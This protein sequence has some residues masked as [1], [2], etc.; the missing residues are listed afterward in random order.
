MVRKSNYLFWDKEEEA[1][2]DDRSSESHEHVPPSEYE[3]WGWIWSSLSQ[4]QFQC[5]ASAWASAML[6]AMLGLQYTL[7]SYN[8]PLNYSQLLFLVLK[9]R[10]RSS[11]VETK[12]D[13]AGLWRDE[14]LVSNKTISQERFKDFFSIHMLPYTLTLH[15]VNPHTR[16]NPSVCCFSFLFWSIPSS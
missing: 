16:S 8:M 7:F 14:I 13:L 12:L 3:M 5:P 10:K 4:T 15:G 9:Y 1:E 11:R 6:S 2:R